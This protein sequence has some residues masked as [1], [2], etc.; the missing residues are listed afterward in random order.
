MRTEDII[1]TQKNAARPEGGRRRRLHEVA[2]AA[3][4][5]V[6]QL[7]LVE[8]AVEALEVP[9]EDEAHDDRQAVR[10]DADRVRVGVRGA[11]VLW[12]DVPVNSM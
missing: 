1:E 10:R 5:A 11:P 12:P 4:A 8:L 7:L 6:L 9:L 3:R 2:E